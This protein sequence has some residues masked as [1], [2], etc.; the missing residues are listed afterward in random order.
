MQ[1]DILTV[2]LSVFISEYVCL[3]VCVCVCLVR[4]GGG[5]G[6]GGGGSSRG[7]RYGQ[8]VVKVNTSRDSNSKSSFNIHKIHTIIF[9]V[10]ISSHEPRRIFKVKEM[11]EGRERRERRRVR[12]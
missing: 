9:D 3:S 12:K 11:R 2:H 8:Q 10:R 6:G 5:G 1:T 4:G 7:D